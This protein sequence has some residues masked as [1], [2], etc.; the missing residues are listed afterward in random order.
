MRPEATESR[1]LAALRAATR[2]RHERL[3]AWLPLARPGAGRAEYAAH[4]DAMRGWLA[5][6]EPALWDGGWPPEV[7]PSQRACKVAWLDE[8]IAIA[9]ADG[10]L[11]ESPGLVSGA[12]RFGSLAER[13]GWGYV[14][15]GSLLGGRA[16]LARLG[17]ELA[18]WP[19]RFLA[20]YGSEGGRRWSA[21]LSAM[22]RHLRGP[23][24]IDAAAAAAAAAFASIDDW[25]QWRM[26]AWAGLA[27]R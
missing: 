8:D 11:G 6:I 17:A 5:P 23:R 10:F 14:V 1:A 25:F 12:P 13:M 18:P 27:R 26:A 19:A 22:E 7:E 21:F 3:E 16:L 2:S 20:G 9:R 24:E 15:E 4:V